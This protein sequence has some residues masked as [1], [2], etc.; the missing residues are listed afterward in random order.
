[1]ANDRHIENRKTVISR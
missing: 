1:M